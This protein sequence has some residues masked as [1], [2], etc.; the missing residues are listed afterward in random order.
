MIDSW[1]SPYQG[2]SANL[3][4]EQNCRALELTS[5]GKGVVLSRQFWLYRREVTLKLGLKSEL[6][7][8]SGNW[9]E[10]SR[11]E[12][13]GESIDVCVNIW[14][15]YIFTYNTSGTLYPGLIWRK[16]K[17]LCWV[18]YLILCWSWRCFSARQQSI[19]FFHSYIEFSFHSLWSYSV[20]F[21]GAI[22]F[23]TDAITCHLHTKKKKGIILR[24]NRPNWCPVV[25]DGLKQ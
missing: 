19:F 16:K 13:L 5:G 7:L 18:V 9:T 14:T 11:K 4:W 10:H 17:G 3:S 8:S 21:G 25:T 6:Y 23:S 20:W 1:Y 24:L 15:V 2:H 22:P 12:K